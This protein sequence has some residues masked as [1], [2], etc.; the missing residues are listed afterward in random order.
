MCGQSFYYRLTDYFWYLNI[1]LLLESDR[2]KWGGWRS[3]SL[4]TWAKHTLFLN[5]LAKFDTGFDRLAFSCFYL[6]SFY[7]I[8][9]IEEKIRY[10]AKLFYRKRPLK[11]T[12]NWH[13]SKIK[14]TNA[15]I[16]ISSSSC[17][18][19]TSFLQIFLCEFYRSNPNK[20]RCDRD[21]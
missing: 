4:L 15:N 18:L 6:C 10:N 17:L 1:T 2:R 21:A 7:T 16:V 8:E 12:F 13:V 9:D 19:F 3:F 5:F 14:V 20:S 11:F